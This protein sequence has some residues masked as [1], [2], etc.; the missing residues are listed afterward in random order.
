MRCELARVRCDLSVL[1]FMRSRDLRPGI[2][3][4]LVVKL[5]L[6]VD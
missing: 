2:M 6:T 4:E 3:N 5:S 1:S